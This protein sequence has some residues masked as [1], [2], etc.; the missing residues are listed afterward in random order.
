MRYDLNHKDRTRERLLKAAADQMRL[1]GPDGVSVA[2]VMKRAGL[3]HG[4]FYAHFDSKDALIAAALGAMFDDA[5]RR[6]VRTGGMAGS[7][8]S[9]IDLYVSAAHRDN[10][11]GGCPIPSLMGESARWP[12]VARAE[13]D[14]GV[15]RLAQ[16][17]GE[18]LPEDL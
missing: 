1:H 8:D 10:A 7:I 12:K 6:R 9:F 5:A 15:A 3:T 17:L 11:R 16:L 14:R 18:L 2:S 4:G 13:F